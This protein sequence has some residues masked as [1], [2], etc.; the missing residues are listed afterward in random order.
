MLYY[1]LSLGQGQPAAGTQAKVPENRLGNQSLVETGL[2]WGFESR[3]VEQASWVGTK[4]SKAMRKEIDAEKGSRV[5]G[6][7]SGKC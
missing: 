7:G 3:R 1:F 5:R 2:V 4:T 6:Q